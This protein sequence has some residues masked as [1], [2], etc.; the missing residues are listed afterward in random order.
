MGND[1]RVVRGTDTHTTKLEGGAWY[2]LF[3]GADHGFGDVSIIVTDD[4]TRTSGADPVDDRHP[5][6]STLS[7]TEGRGRFTI[8]DVTVE[9]VAGDVVVVPADAWHSY[10]NTG[11]CAATCCRRARQRPPQGESSHLTVDRPTRRTRRTG[12]CALA[13]CLG[14]PCAGSYASSAK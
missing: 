2:Q 12:Q 11:D 9:A 6:I 5:H 13:D 14:E 8:D 1:A 4:A 3:D 7:I 10:A